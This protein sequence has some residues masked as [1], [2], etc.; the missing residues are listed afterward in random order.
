MLRSDR[1]VKPP[2]VSQGRRA[3]EEQARMQYRFDGRVAIVT[4]AGKGLGR[5]FALELARRGA[6]V[7]VNNRAH[8]DDALRSADAVVAEIRDGGGEAVANH[9]SV[10]A[11][12]AA[13]AIV[14]Q[15]LDAWGRVD[16]VIHNA[17]VAQSG[18]FT[19]MDA[20][21]FERTM[22]VNF[23]AP[24]ALTR[25]V[26]PQLRERGYGRMLFCTSAAGLY[27]NRGQSAYSASKAALLAF[28]QSIRLEESRYD[29]RANAIAP[30]AE[31]QMTAAY[32]QSS[33]PGTFDARFPAALAAW[34]VHA[35]CPANGEIVI[36]GARQLRAAR[37]L[38][39][40]GFAFADPT[41]PSVEGVARNF[42]AVR[43]LAGA[44]APDSADACF[45]RFLCGADG[46]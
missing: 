25:A 30:F 13:D 38:E 44:T 28:M 46:R 32:M 21:E 12:G 10:E 33:A 34:L 22:R 27:G 41:E 45:A 23:M 35:D 20:E 2:G 17:A 7:L 18:Y 39:G 40:S 14:A 19:R 11:E 4:G 42:D 43:S 37:M 36:A 31:T 5:A 9:A 1:C 16:I 8:A 15:A 29:F 3:L 24:V 26:L 6:R